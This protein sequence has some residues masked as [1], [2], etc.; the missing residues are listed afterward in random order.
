MVNTDDYNIGVFQDTI[1]IFV[2]NCKEYFDCFYKI[3]H[4]NDLAVKIMINC[5]NF[6]ETLVNMDFEYIMMD[7]VDKQRGVNN[8]EWMM[9]A[10]MCVYGYHFI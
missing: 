10:L 3:M 8:V 6:L 5:T 4:V 2:E 1:L 7:T 9:L